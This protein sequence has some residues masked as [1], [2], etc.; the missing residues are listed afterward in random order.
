MTD[1]FIM[2]WKNPADLVRYLLKHP[3]SRIVYLTTDQRMYVL[4]AVK[5]TD[6]LLGL[7]SPYPCGR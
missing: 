3:P 1:P 5:D 4:V 7:D 2:W 6:D